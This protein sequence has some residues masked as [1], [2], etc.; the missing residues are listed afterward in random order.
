M[1]RNLRRHKSIP[2]TDRSSSGEA[3]RAAVTVAASLGFDQERCHDIGIVA[4]EAANNI[5]S[6]ARGG[7]V[8]IC[9]AMDERPALELLAL[10]KGPGI[11][12]VPRAF[13]DGYSTAGTAGQGLGAIKRLS[14][15]VSLYSVPSQG[16]VLYAQ[17]TASETTV[18]FG[19]VNVPIKGETACGDTFLALPG[20]RRS[21]Y[22]VAD[23]LGHGPGASEAAEEARSVVQRFSTANV[24]E[25]FSR[26]HDALRKTRGAAMSVA[27]VDHELLLVTYGGVGNVSGSLVGAS[28]TRSMVSQN[29]TLGAVL[30]KLQE[31]TYPFE[32]DTTLVM[33]SDG[34]TSKCALSGYPGIRLRPLTLIAGLLYRDF[35][36][37]RD[38]ATVLIA[39]LRSQP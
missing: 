30:P 16:T 24:T 4:T 38:D 35:T 20:K 14:D 9:P 21:V 23:G 34:L 3:R 31:F 19:A 37:G 39:N 10:D 13:E 36:R 2:I 33:F 27:I 26:S 11:R 18:P 8:L 5:C 7:E 17:F 25:I 15:V 1:I 32:A 12:D 29:G 28:T 6:H 22:M